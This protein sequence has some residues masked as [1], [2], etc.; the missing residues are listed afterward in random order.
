M[1]VFVIGWVVVLFVFFVFLLSFEGKIMT[2]KNWNLL[3]STF[4]DSDLYKLVFYIYYSVSYTLD[5]ASIKGAP[6]D[7][8]FC[9]G[10]TLIHL[11]SL[12]M[13][14]FNFIGFYFLWFYA[15]QHTFPIPIN[16]G[17]KN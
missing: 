4:L 14:W 6:R 16:E 10:K 13:E 7:I 1:A 5:N 12:N 8:N 2:E 9:T 3:V 11:Q 15:D 17:D